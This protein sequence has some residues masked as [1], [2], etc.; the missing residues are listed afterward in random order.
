MQ[1]ERSEGLQKSGS[2]RRHLLKRYSNWRDHDDPEFV[3]WVE[4]FNH[5]LHLNATPLSMAEF[6]RRR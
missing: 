3:R 6:F 5:A 1:A 2:E 4:F